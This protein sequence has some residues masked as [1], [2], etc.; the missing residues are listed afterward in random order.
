MSILTDNESMA[1]KLSNAQSRLALATQVEETTIKYLK[2]LTGKQPE[3]EDI[4]P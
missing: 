3:P 2:L 1:E 4:L